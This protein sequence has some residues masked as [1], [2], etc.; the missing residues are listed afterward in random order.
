[1]RVNT[2]GLRDIYIK[3]FFTVLYIQCLL[4]FAKT[5]FEEKKSDWLLILIIMF[6]A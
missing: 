4:I 3:L 2:C 5:T 1:M 6:D